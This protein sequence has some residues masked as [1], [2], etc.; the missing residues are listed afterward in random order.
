ME[1]YMQEILCI[2]GSLDREWKTV[3]VRNY[4]FRWAIPHTSLPIA[5]DDLYKAVNITME[6]EEY[7]IIRYHSPRGNTFYQGEYRDE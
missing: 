1:D 2:G 6:I 5:P 3:D 7:D 4:C